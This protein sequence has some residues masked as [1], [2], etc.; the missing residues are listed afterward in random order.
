MDAKKVYLKVYN[1]SMVVGWTFILVTYFLK[2]LETGFDA[3]LMYPHVRIALMIFQY[4]AILEIFHAITGLVPSP[5]GTTI[6]QVFSRV[7]LVAVLEYIP[8]S[9]ALGF[10]LLGCAWSV[11]EVI[12][13]SFYSFK[14]F[15]LAV[16]Y[17]LLW[18]RYSFFIV[19]YPMGVSGEVITLFKSLPYFRTVTVFGLFPASYIIW[20]LILYYIP[21]LYMLYTYMLSQRKKVLGKKNENKPVEVLNKKDN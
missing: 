6:T 13:Y 8:E 18:C 1:L 21:G 9:R 2:A 14:L 5:L 16:P 20:A 19:L 11:T 12:R 15:G 4:G 17:P 3:P 10:L 7:V